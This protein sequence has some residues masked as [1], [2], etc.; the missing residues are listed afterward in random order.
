MKNFVWLLALLITPHLFAQ[1]ETDTLVAEGYEFTPVYEIET[2]SVKDQSR[3]GTC[4]SFA[5]TSFLETELI[6]QGKPALD[7]SEMF[8]VYHCYHQKAARYVRYHGK[9]NFSAGG[10]AHDIMQVIEEYGLV[11]ETAYPGLLPNLEHHNHGEMD[12][13]LNGY[14]KAVV[15]NRNKKLSPV[16]MNGFKAVESNYLG[17]LPSSFNYEE[18]TYSPLSFKE[19]LSIQPSDYIEITS[20][21]HHPYYESFNLEIPD[22]WNFSNYY[23]L[24]IDELMEVINHAME[25]GYSVCWDGDVSDKGFSHRNGVAIVPE[26]NTTEMEGTERARWEK[27]TAKEKNAEL[28]SFTAPGNEKTITQETRQEH[29][30]NYSS[31]D[32]HLMHLTGMVKDQNGTLY[33]QTKNSWAEDSNDF[34]GYLNMSSAYIRLNTVAIMIHKSALPKALAKKLHIK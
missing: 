31:T 29:F 26:K 2:T 9:S 32:D 8:F 6:R 5:A 18:K 23:N 34:G 30:N 11:P 10:Q 16:W 28:Y 25:N 7:L 1:N 24:P 15:T 20:Y 4:W 3:S 22:N 27:L 33:Y 13:V 21:A 17:T 19:H 12:A 14:I